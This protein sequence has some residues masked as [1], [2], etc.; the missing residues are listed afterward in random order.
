[1]GVALPLI[2]GGALGNLVDRLSMD[3]KVVDFI[4]VYYKG[5]SWP[6]F[7]VADMAITAGEILLVIAFFSGELPELLPGGTCEEKDGAGPQG[8]VDE[9]SEPPASTGEDGKKG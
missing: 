8:V 6:V 5:F 3:L 1:M 7:N 9:E 2:F 4:R